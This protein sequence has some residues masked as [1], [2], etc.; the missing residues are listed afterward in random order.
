MKIKIDE[1]MKEKLFV[2]CKVLR[3]VAAGIDERRDKVI[4]SDEQSLSLI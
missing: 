4:S 3:K 1:M 2:L